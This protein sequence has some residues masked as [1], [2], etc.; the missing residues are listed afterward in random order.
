[1]PSQARCRQCRGTAITK[2]PTPNWQTLH[3]SSLVSEKSLSRPT[4]TRN[5]EE[6]QRKTSKNKHQLGPDPLQT[7]DSKRT[8]LLP[9]PLSNS[10]PNWVLRRVSGTTPRESNK[11]IAFCQ[12]FFLSFFMAEKIAERLTWLEVFVGFLVFENRLSL[13]VCHNIIMTNALLVVNV[14]NQK[15]SEFDQWF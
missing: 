4:C 14:G 13:V 1:M 9:S 7:N 15:N 12:G 2:Q 8:W 3:S 10:E 11:S 6:V 5:L